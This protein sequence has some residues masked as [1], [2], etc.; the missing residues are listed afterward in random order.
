MYNTSLVIVIPCYN[1]YDRFPIQEYK[2]FL[3]GRPDASICIVDDASTDGT[4]NILKE[5]QHEL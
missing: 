2:D 1:E 3:S 5:L 4:S